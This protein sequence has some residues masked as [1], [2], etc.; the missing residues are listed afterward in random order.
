MTGRNCSLF[1]ARV[2]IYLSLAFLFHPKSILFF[3][4]ITYTHIPSQTVID[5][6]S[7]RFFLQPPPSPGLALLAAISDLAAFFF[8]HSVGSRFISAC[9]SA[10]T[11]PATRHRA[12]AF[13]MLNLW[14]KGMLYTDHARVGLWCA[15]SC[16]LFWRWGWRGYAS[17]FWL[18]G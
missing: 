17:G 12:V 18:S 13:R 7:P 10:E 1:E 14:G 11:C 2:L 16:W 9:R 4:L 6:P 15:Y 5:D 3:H 8:G